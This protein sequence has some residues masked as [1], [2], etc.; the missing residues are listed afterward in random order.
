MRE[1]SSTSWKR[2]G[3]SVVF[4]REALAP[5]IG[6]E[7][8]M[9]SLRA[10]LG[11]LDTFPTQPPAQATI[12]VTGL[13][14]ALETQA[15]AAAEVFLGRQVARLIE[16]VQ[17]QWDRRGLVFGFAAPANAFEVSGAQEEV[18]FKVQGRRQVRLSFGL[19]D[20]SATV[21]LARLFADRPTGPAAI[22]F[23]VAR[24]S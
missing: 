16:R 13:E 4:D 23:H 11:W 12:L 1:I 15:P 17:S 6:G 8:S 7:A 22:G 3:S 9:V 14:A 5:L 24:V 10:A 18:L 19:W 20:G 21:N 2:R